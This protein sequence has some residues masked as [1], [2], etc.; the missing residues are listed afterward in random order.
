MG[1]GGGGPTV[2][3]LQ[4][5]DPPGEAASEALGLL[6]LHRLQ[7]RDLR[8]QPVAGR[9]HRGELGVVLTCGGGDGQ[10]KPP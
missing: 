5:H 8:Q 6:A 7:Q 1:V 9:G 4:L 3:V 2:S 10:V